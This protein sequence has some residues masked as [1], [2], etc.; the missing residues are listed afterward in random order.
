MLFNKLKIFY[1]NNSNL[2]DGIKLQNI[3]D[4]SFKPI[5]GSLWSSEGFCNVND[6]TSD[7]LLEVKNTF[8][9]RLQKQEKILPSVVI[10]NKL[11]EKIDLIESK[12]KRQVW[13]KEKKDIKDNLIFELLPQAFSKISYADIIL[14][15]RNNFLFINEISNNRVDTI[16][17]KIKKSIGNI[18]ISSIKTNLNPSDV[19]TSWLIYGKCP[20]NFVIN[21]VCELY[22]CNVNNFSNIKIRD[23]NLYDDEIISLVK[24][25]KKVIKLGLIWNNRISF[26]VDENLSIQRIKFLDIIKD[27]ENKNSYELFL[28]NHILMSENFSLLLNDLI[29]EFGGLI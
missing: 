15:I 22:S 14:D 12:E 20:S 1:L 3:I 6:F 29:L 7:L 24:K 21:D 13:H 8:R 18:N 5:F 27:D 17:T 11:K 4:N 26:V 10:N 28:S 9:L 2:K 19:M 16:V 25:D 23:Q